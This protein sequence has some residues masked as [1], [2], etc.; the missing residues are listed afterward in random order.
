MKK[1]PP[2]S[3][4]LCA[5]RSRAFAG[6]SDSTTGGARHSELSWL[7]RIMIYAAGLTRGYALSATYSPGR[8]PMAVLRASMGHGELA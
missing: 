5:I 1:T 6:G 7:H 8:S 3:I 4:T 2:W